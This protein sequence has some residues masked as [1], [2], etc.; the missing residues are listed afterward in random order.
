MNKHTTH[1]ILVDRTRGLFL[2]FSNEKAALE[3]ADCYPLAEVIQ[4]YETTDVAGIPLN[5]IVGCL[6]GTHWYVRSES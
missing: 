5:R 2:A 6:G 1:T 3:S 4:A